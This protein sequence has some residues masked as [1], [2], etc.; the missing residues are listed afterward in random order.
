MNL[1]TLSNRPVFVAA[2]GGFL[3]LLLR[4]LLYRIGFDDR[5]I[6]SA[7]HPLQLACLVLAAVVILYLALKSRSLPEYPDDQSQLRFLL[8]LAAGCLLLLQG[9]TL[10]HQSTASPNLNHLFSGSLPTVRRVTAL[11][12]LSRCLLTALAGIAMAICGL[13]DAKNRSLSAV[14]H[15]A[16]CVV[17]AADMLGRYQSWSGNPQLPDYVFHVLAGVALSLSAYQ[18]LALHTG[19]GKLRI[20][21]FWCLSALFLCILCLAGPE[22]RAFYLS[23]ACWALFCLLTPMPPQAREPEEEASDVSA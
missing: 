16:V 22:P 6:L 5:G 21:R 9:L 14:C 20:H 13:P 11:L 2:C 8:G 3:G 1:R 17:F 15:G 10:Y 23:G 12:P 18:S 19:L 4:A 7:S